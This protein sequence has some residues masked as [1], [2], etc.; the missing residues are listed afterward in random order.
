MY[1]TL[2]IIH[3]HYNLKSKADTVLEYIGLGVLAVGLVIG[4][5]INFYAIKKYNGKIF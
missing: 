5:A 1:M 2:I 4:L 3:I